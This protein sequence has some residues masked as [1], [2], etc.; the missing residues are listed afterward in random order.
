MGYKCT[1]SG[2]KVHKRVHE[3]IV[4]GTQEKISCL[5]TDAASIQIRRCRGPL[6]MRIGNWDRGAAHRQAVRCAESS[7]LPSPKKN[8]V[9]PGRHGRKRN[10]SSLEL[11]A[12]AKLE[13]SRS[14]KRVR[15]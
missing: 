4:S 14:A 3:V 6:T 10:T 5:E 13:L 12:Q 8:A 7:D 9:A 2:D 11:D 15:S 1:L